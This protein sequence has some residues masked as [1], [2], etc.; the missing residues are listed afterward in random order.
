MNAAG[1]TDPAGALDAYLGVRARLPDA[2][3]P[4]AWQAAGDLRDIAEG[5]DLILLDAYG[6][7]N[8]GE[9]PIPGAAGR[10]ADLRA[11]GKPSMVVSNSAG[12]PKRRMM[13]RYAR[14]G[15]DFDPGEVVTS[16][17][18]LLA[19]LASAPPRRWGLMLDP[20]PGDEELQAFGCVPLGEDRAAYD[21]VDGF[22]LVGSEGW[23]DA[24]QAHLEASLLD[25]PRPVCVGNPDLV[26]P[27]EGGLSRE[28]GHFAHRLIRRTGVAPR[29][30]GKPFPDIF[31][32]AL[33]RRPAEAAR[34][35][36]VGDTL[37]TDILGGRHMGFSTALVT[38]S[39]SLAGLDVADAI[40]RSGIVPD[41][42]IGRI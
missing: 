35:L 15:F 39:G 26:A 7:L 19:H 34:V 36:M 1:A 24:R 3:F 13:D 32:L 22:L 38:G 18:V 41:Y 27:R 42:V 21:R 40:A 25:D 8:V 12:Y 11:R 20:A 29:F 16:R 23:T 5:F 4:A 31:E 10:V 17:E 14:L 28:P 6:V 33:E 2:T 37:H 9:T 30:F